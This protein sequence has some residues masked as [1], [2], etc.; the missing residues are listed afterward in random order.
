MKKLYLFLL[1]LIIFSCKAEK[2]AGIKPITYDLKGDSPEIYL[3][4]KTFNVAVVNYFAT[5]CSPCKKEMPELQKIYDSYS[6]KG[7]IVVGV[8]QEKQQAVSIIEKIAARLK[9]NYPILYN[10]SANIK[11]QSVSVL[12]YTIIFDSEMNIIKE[13]SGLFVTNDLKMQ[14]DSILNNKVPD[15]NIKTKFE[16]KTLYN[17]EAG[18][19]AG[20]ITINVTGRSGYD[21]GKDG[22]P[23]A[24]IVITYPNSGK[25]R[26]FAFEPSATGLFV[27]IPYENNPNTLSA[28]IKAYACSETSCIL[29]DEDLI[30]DISTK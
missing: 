25:N 1:L 27:K 18:Y 8:T 14:L 12:P 29:I 23:N 28:H 15:S 11:K 16:N 4:D 10:S 24:T 21:L 3:E 26:E 9:V 17:A 20:F 5:Y 13:I 2:Y 19:N 22:Y 6:S 30:L 7:V